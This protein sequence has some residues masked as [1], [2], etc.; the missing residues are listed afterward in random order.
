MEQDIINIFADKLTERLNGKFTLNWEIDR[1]GVMFA[2]CKLNNASDITKTAEIVADFG[3]RV[4]TISALIKSCYEDESLNKKLEHVEINY[5]FYF[6]KINCT[7]SISLPNDKREIESITP[8]L[9]SADWHEREMQDFYKIKL[10][11]HPNPRRLFLSKDIDLDKDA[12]IPLSAAMK[13]SSTSTLWEKVMQAGS[14]GGV[15][16][17]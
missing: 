16:N 17:E 5:H 6:E 11:G 9:K 2:W 10:I 14:K 8:I 3:G 7:V 15:Q 12:M 4:M 1:K 13:G